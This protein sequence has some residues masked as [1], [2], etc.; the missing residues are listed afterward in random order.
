MAIKRMWLGVGCCLAGLVGRVE[1]AGRPNVVFVLADQWRGQAL[2]FAGDPNVKTPN[3]D[4]LAGESLDFENAVSGLPVC[5]PTRASLLTGERATTHGVFLNDAHLAAERVTFA[6]VLGGAGYETGII[7]KWHVNG[8][9][10]LSFIPKEDRQGFEYWKVMECEHAYNNSFYYGDGPEKLKWEGYDAIAQTK[11]ACGYIKDK[12]KEGKPFLLCLW[13]GPPHNPYGSAPEEYKAMYKPGKIQLRPN[14]PGAEAEQ[15]RKDLAGYYAHCSALDHCMGEVWE[16]LKQAGVEENTIVIFSADHGDMLWSQGFNRK[17]KPWEESIRVPML[18][19][20]P[21]GLGREGKKV[22]AVMCSEDVM[23]TML[24]LCGVKI[25]ESGVEGLD[26]SGY[27]KGG[28]NPNKE[29]AALISCVAPFSEWSRAMGGREFRG[30]RTGRYTYVRQLSGPWL[31]Y[32]NEK[33]PY[34]MENLVGKG[35]PVEKE[36]DGVLTE[37][38]KEA[39]DEFKPANYY[40]QKWGYDKLVN[41]TGALS[42]EP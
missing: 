20:W 4:R 39:G 10:R 37:K 27:M 7:G 5:S 33:D 6:E 29:N 41:K 1:G 12:G 32:D 31:L 9:G 34:Q 40:L 26:Y 8:K 30:V 28:A 3:L 21:A 14:V 23:P 11:D 22:D 24:G 38:L 36:L 35:L 15:A 13:W 17:Q 19:H 25:P 2:G 16:A 18:W 42:T